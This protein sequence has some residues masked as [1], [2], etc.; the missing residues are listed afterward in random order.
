MGLLKGSKKAGK[1]VPKAEA[2][3]N[4]AVAGDASKAG[5]KNSEKKVSQPVA[6]SSP[7]GKPKASTLANAAHADALKMQQIAKLKILL[8]QKLVSHATLSKQLVE[9]KS[10]S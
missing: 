8:D 3:T 4:K 7:D 1:E 10:V 6:A 9:K 5:S 2:Q